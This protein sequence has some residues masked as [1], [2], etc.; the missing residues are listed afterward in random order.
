MHQV[1]SGIRIEDNVKISQHGPEYENSNKG[2]GGEHLEL[3]H[4]PPLASNISDKTFIRHNNNVLEGH[5]RSWPCSS[6]A[7]Y[8]SNCQNQHIKYNRCEQV[9]LQTLER[10]QELCIDPRGIN[11]NKILFISQLVWFVTPRKDEKSNTYTYYKRAKVQ[12]TYGVH[13]HQ[14]LLFRFLSEINTDQANCLLCIV[15]SS[16]S[17]TGFF[18][19]CP[20]SRDNRVF[21]IGY[22]IYVVDPDPIEE[23]I[24]CVPIIVSN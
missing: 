18:N 15:Q 22:I 5:A 3:P 8:D 2:D 21:S 12:L 13:Y 7:P 20:N 19:S 16:T 24:N 11:I 14:I 23:Y 6:F 4:R 9:N 1:N 10:G 17:N